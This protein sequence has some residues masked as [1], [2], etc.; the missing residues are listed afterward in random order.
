MMKFGTNSWFACIVALAAC[1]APADDGEE[2]N[3]GGGAGT[4]PG[5]GTSGGGSG[6][7]GGSGTSGGGGSNVS[8][9]GTGGSRAGGTGG[10]GGGMSGG[11]AAG[12]AG[13]VSNIMCDPATDAPMGECADNATG[14]FAIKTVIDVW[15]QDEKND[16]DLVDP[17]RDTITVYL[18]G[19]IKDVKCDGSGGVG[20]MKACGTTLPPFK[21][22]A[23]CDAFQITFP[24]ELWDKPSMPTFE[25]TGT[26]T[27]FDVG[28]VLSIAE[29]TGLL[30]VDLT[31]PEGAWPAKTSD[32]GFEMVDDDGDGKPGITIVMGRIGEV[33]QKGTC[34]GF[35]MQD[36]VFRG[37]PLETI[38]AID[39]AGEKAET[40]YIGLRSKLGGG[41]AIGATC[42][43]GT[44]DSKATYL[45]SRVFDCVTTMDRPCVNHPDYGTAARDFVD[46][47]APTYHILQAGEK[48]PATVIEPTTTMPLD[49][50]PSVGAKSSLVRLA[51]LG[52]SV[53]CAMVR[54]AAYP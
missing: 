13:S 27:G 8:T 20:I 22:D 34:G 1:G 40:L 10:G 51:D 44:G 54:G 32:G 2:N 43:S 50:T 52:G 28:S 7:T 48:P 49:Q 46:N 23:N 38:S 33:F 19:E 31:D 16:P 14:I 3:G 29:A 39:D 11:G 36:F 9:A 53:D 25:T 35:L 15:W 42:D 45:D 24:D 6:T 37:A 5:A 18:R 47:S 12:T 21:S 30:G 26:T 17:G 4:T 41:G